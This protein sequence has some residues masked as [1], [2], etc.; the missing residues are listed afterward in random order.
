MKSITEDKEEIINLEYCNGV[1]LRTSSVGKEGML[2]DSFN[3]G[4]LAHDYNVGS[5]N[6][7]LEELSKEVSLDE[8]PEKIVT[9]KTIFSEIFLNK[10]NQENSNNNVA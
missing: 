8:S 2:G 7:C 5:N 6:V 10:K 4:N 1:E 9:S 3:G